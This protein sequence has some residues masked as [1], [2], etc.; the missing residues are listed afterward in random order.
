MQK[1]EK[2]WKNLL[3]NNKAVQLLSKYLIGL[4]RE[5]DE[6]DI[7]GDIL[8]TNMGYDEILIEESSKDIIDVNSSKRDNPLRKTKNNKL[9]RGIS[10]LYDKRTNVDDDS[11]ARKVELIY[12]CLLKFRGLIRYMNF[13]GLKHGDIKK[14]SYFI[15]HVS[16]NRGEYIFR[17]GDKSDALYGV[18]TGKVIIRFI[19]PIDFLRKLSYENIL[20]EDLIPVNNIPID[21]FISDCEEESSEEPDS[22]NENEK[23]KNSNNSLSDL[24][25]NNNDND[26]NDNNNDNNE[27][28]KKIKKKNNKKKLTYGPKKK[29]LI[30]DEDV[31][32]E[33][34]KILKTEEELDEA[35]E[36]KI[37]KEKKIELEN[38]IKR[39]KSNLKKPK[40][41]K[42]KKI[43][44]SL[45]PN[46]TPKE[47]I[48]GEILYDFIKEFE[49]EN[50]IITNGMCFGEWGLVYSIPRTTSIYCIE[51]CNLFYLEKEYFNRILSSKFAQSDSLKINFLIK[52][53]PILKSDIRIGHILTKIVPLFFENENIVY[54]PF[55][56]AENLFVVYQG[57]CALI[58]LDKANNKE[59]YL[60]KRNK[61]KII[62][63]LTVGGIAGF[64]SC[65][66]NLLYYNNAL[67]ITKEFTTLLKVNI[68]NMCEKYK[69][70]KE[71][72]YPLFEEQKKIYEKIHS[73]GEKVKEIHKVH[74]FNKT[75]YFINVEKIAQNAL[76]YEK[77]R[78]F[79][80]DFK[81]NKIELDKREII[82]LKNDENFWKNNNI[83]YLKKGKNRKLRLK[84]NR[85]IFNSNSNMPK[86]E[87]LH[88]KTLSMNN[89][90]K[91]ILSPNKKNTKDKYFSSS[92]NK[93]FNSVFYENISTDFNTYIKSKR[94]TE[95][96][97][98]IYSGIPDLKN[99]LFRNKSRN[100]KT[101]LIHY[102]S[103]ERNSIKNINPFLNERKLDFYHSGKFNLPFLTEV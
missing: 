56:K 65:S 51:D 55:D 33:E 11:D 45:V 91:N 20:E 9:N 99:V 77:K 90:F 31:S 36:E 97:D 66:E 18:I 78:T 71:N 98:L 92:K 2:T 14:I 57:E 96:N 60:I 50:F 52:T 84:S 80:N 87:R 47:D 76:L 82:K 68:K 54:T 42:K 4:I 30:L 85:L 34:E 44:K 13:Q 46:Q 23:K 43:I 67:L 95:E 12:F 48:M 73:K 8:K 70:F 88:F 64:E 15:R 59:D 6:K 79:S 41:E 29:Y 37:L 101:N 21:Y 7:L 39:Q 103:G 38:N 24:E 5:M 74:G 19:K 86:I 75:N 22:E 94:L 40:K 93:K 25:K 16:F 72:V 27:I 102:N 49:Y 32:L 35:I 58:S 53:F 63:R 83:D 10:S 17:Q 61:Y 69:D 3:M 81:L 26:N 62:S 100:V 1:M 89:N 28:K